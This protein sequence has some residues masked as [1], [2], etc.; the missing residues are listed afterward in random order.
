[1]KTRTIHYL[2]IIFKELLYISKPEIV[3]KSYPAKIIFDWTFSK[4]ML[5]TNSALNNNLCKN[6]Y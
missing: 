3:V 4:F 1:M 2:L 5:N 6:T